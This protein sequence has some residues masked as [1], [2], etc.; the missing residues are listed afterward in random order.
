MLRVS[1]SVGVCVRQFLMSRLGDGMKIGR[2]IFFVTLFISIL[3]GL[4][5]HALE[6]RSEKDA[7]TIIELYTSEGCSSCPSADAW[8]SSLANDPAIFSRF[9][10]LA[11]HVDYWNQLGWQ[12]RF[13]TSM[14]SHRQRE[15][16][17]VGVL[18]QVYT[19]GFVINNREWRGWFT[20][21]RS[22]T[23][24]KLPQSEKQ[25]GTL[26]AQW[27]DNTQSLSFSYTPN[28]GDVKDLQLH[29]AIVGMGLKTNVR[30]GENR[31][32]VLRHDF[33]VL[34]YTQYPF[35][36]SKSGQTIRKSIAEPK[37]PDEGQ[38][39]SALVVWVS[40]SSSPEII[41]AVAGYL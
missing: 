8:L 26:T 9:I 17:R 28:I 20:R 5:A 2:G 6:L 35:G 39:R 36:S 22:V 41:Q 15:L 24:D 40:E 33:V 10:P 21:G 1:L 23:A 7:T 30:R 19:P 37:I 16:S 18:S 13:S 29:V 14:N 4:P 3:L 25:V 11:F 38:S 32:R 12:D 31:G 34:S 27:P